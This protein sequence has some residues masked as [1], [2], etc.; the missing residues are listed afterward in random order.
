[1]VPRST[2]RHTRGSVL[3]AA[4]VCLIVALLLGAALARSIVL[5][6][7]MARA[8]LQRLQAFWLAEAGVARAAAALR[9]KADY[10]GEVWQFSVVGPA[11]LLPSAVQIRVETVPD[12][13]QKRLIRAEARV[14]ESVL[15]GTAYRKQLVIQLP[16]GGDTP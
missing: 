16:A 15:S 1:V 3:T 10:P 2:I 14:P 5:Q 13:P 9:S 11:G 4:I 12:Q 8:E 6:H 7:R